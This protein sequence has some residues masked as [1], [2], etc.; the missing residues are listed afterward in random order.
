[1]RIRF[2][3]TSP[4]TLAF[5]ARLPRR[6]ALRLALGVALGLAACPAELLA[7]P[8]AAGG[9]SRAQ[10]ATLTSLL[11]TLIPA[12]A[13]SPSASQAGVLK[14]LLHEVRFDASFQKLLRLGCDWIALQ[15]GGDFAVAS[16]DARGYVL[17]WM[18]KAAPDTLPRR[19]FDVMRDSALALYYTRPASWRG[20]RI[21]A[22]PQPV[23]Y[24]EIADVTP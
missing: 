14:D 13:L 21:D 4:Q 8:L 3:V 17:D 16:L 2:A 18:A 10:L 12:D 5:A 22:S 23:G 6:E 15:T 11:D 7:A 19:F 9:L 24:P 20:S 1:M